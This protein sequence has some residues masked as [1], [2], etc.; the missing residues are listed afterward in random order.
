MQ[1]H[2]LLKTAEHFLEVVNTHL[3][4]DPAISFLG[5]YLRYTKLKVCKN[6][7]TQMFIAI[8]FIIDQV[9]NNN[10]MDRQIMFMLVKSMRD[11][12]VDE[13]LIYATTWVDLSKILP[14]KRSIAYIP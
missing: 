4:Y 3:P 7:L 9:F 10:R 12:T 14:F 6:L 1:C 2:T 5:V 11:C 8:L 13:L